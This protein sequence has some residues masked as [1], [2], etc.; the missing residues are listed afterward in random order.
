MQP[1]HDPSRSR[2][3]IRLFRIPPRV[4][5]RGSD[6][7]TADFFHHCWPMI[8]EEVWEIIEDSR[9]SGQVLPG[10]QRHFPHPHSQRRACEPPQAVPTDRP[11]QRH[12]QAPNQGDSKATQAYPPLHYLTRTIRVCGGKT[13]LGQRHPSHMKLSTL[14]RRP[15]LQVCS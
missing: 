5:P 2:K 6:G 12:L 3:L 1:W 10:P 14:Y 9:L 13:D 8:R 11:L 7:F 15:A 4:K